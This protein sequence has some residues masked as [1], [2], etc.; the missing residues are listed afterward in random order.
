GRVWI[1]ADCS[2]VVRSR[3]SD[4]KTFEIACVLPAQFWWPSH[5]DIVVPL[6]LD[7]HDRTLRAAHFLE[8]IG[9]LGDG[10]P[11][12]RAREELRIIGKR[13]AQEFPAENAN[14]LPNLRPLRDALVG[15]VR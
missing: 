13:L 10:V 6:A 8:V 12:D 11:G 14:H 4:G 3:A 9:R 15:D 5:P 7:D 1:A 2:A